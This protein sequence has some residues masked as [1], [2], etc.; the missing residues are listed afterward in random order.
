[1]PRE[2]VVKLA[3][4]NTT[5]KLTKEE[6]AKQAIALFRVYR[7]L[8]GLV[9]TYLSYL[10]LTPQAIR[11]P[12]ARRLTAF[13]CVKGAALLPSLV[14]IF[15][16]ADQT[17]APVLILA[18]DPTAAAVARTCAQVR[19]VAAARNAAPVLTSV[20]VRTYAPADHSEEFRFAP[21]VAA[22]QSWL[23]VSR[24]YRLWVSPLRHA[25]LNR[26]FP[27]FPCNPDRV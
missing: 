10:R 21:E 16:V 14:L 1:M 24:R 6:P 15:A 27:A 25:G 5:M 17:W 20:A 11:S 22:S 3:S 7:P 4:S 12:S 2:S 19:N 8:S 9:V 23:A 13:L 26:C 18:A